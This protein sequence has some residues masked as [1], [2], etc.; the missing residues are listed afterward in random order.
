MTYLKKNLAIISVYTHTYRELQVLVEP[1]QNPT[2][3]P[4]EMFVF[5]ILFDILKLPRG[6]SSQV[7]MGHSDVPRP[8]ALLAC[9]VICF[10]LRKFRRKSMCI[11]R[12]KIF[13][14][15]VSEMAFLAF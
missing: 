10:G 8:N 15:R 1:L 12:Q 6:R 14:F 7:V 13:E 2:E 4:Q 11:L 5:D 3:N 9:S